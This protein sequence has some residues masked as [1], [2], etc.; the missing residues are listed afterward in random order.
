LLCL[1]CLGV[2]C[3]RT[4]PLSVEREVVLVDLNEEVAG[5]ADDELGLWR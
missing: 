1:V 4:G 5:C 3:D 2:C